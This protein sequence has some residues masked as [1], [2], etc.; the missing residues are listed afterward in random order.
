MK[1]EEMYDLVVNR[2][3]PQTHYPVTPPLP[4]APAP[5]VQVKTETPVTSLAGPAFSFSFNSLKTPPSF[6]LGGVA[7]KGIFGSSPFAAGG[8]KG[9][10]NAGKKRTMQK[11]SAFACIPV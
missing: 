2:P 6:S 3:P 5:V 4:V 1:F 9:A 7:G 11:Q 10:D 8:G